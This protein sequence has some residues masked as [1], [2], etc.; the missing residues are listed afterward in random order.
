MISNPHWTQNLG[1]FA[2][3]VGSD[4]TAQIETKLEAEEINNSTFAERLDVSPS[5]VSQ[6]LHDPGNLTLG[7]VVK[8]CRTLGMKVALVAYEDDDPDNDKGPINAEVFTKC[9]ERLGKPRDFF[10]LENMRP[11]NIGWI[12]YSQTEATV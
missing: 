9:W 4:F 12:V 1:D 3:W 2:Y 10:D 7:N 8:Y 5:R 6:V 11:S